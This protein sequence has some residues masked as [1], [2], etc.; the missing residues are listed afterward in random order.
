MKMGA[1]PWD[2]VLGNEQRGV[3]TEYN[4]VSAY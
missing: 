3:R 2:G 4:Q 1:D